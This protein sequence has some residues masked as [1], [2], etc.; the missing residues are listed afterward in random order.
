MTERVP[1]AEPATGPEEIP[2]GEPAGAA[3]GETTFAPEGTAP[4]AP[5]AESTWA[6]GAPVEGIE[7][8]EADTST[9]STDAFSAPPPAPEERAPE[10]LGPIPPA[11]ADAGPSLAEPGTEPEAG[12]P[13]VLRLD[14]RDATEADVPATTEPRAD[15]D[16]LGARLVALQM[17]VAGGARGEVEVHLRR[18]FDLVDCSSILDDVFGPGTDA[19]KRV[20]WPR[21]ADGAA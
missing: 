6:G 18:T 3:P 12:S 1:L 8:A 7:P 19:D 10:E 15:D 5:G 11:G 4:A 14:R 17:A 2:A 21:P 13:E 16:Q 9:F 20:A